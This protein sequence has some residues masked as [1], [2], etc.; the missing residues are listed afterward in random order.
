MKEP[1]FDDPRVKEQLQI[2]DDWSKDV[3]LFCDEALNI[4]PAQPLGALCGTPIKY[5][6]PF[7]A[8]QTAILFD[9]RGHLV[10]PDLAFYTRDMFEPWKEA[11]ER[12]LTWQQ[13]VILEAYNR[14]LSTFDADSFD[15]VKRWVST[16]AG[17]GIGKTSCMSIIALHFLVCFPGAQIGATAASEN[18]LKDIFLKEFY[19]WRDKLPDGIKKD[20]TQLDDMV[21]VG[22]GKDW[23]MRARVSRPD[24]PE[25]LAGL[26]G[27]YVL[28]LPD[29]A[30][31]IDNMTFQIMKGALTGKNYIV[32]YFSNG[33]RTEG[34]FWESQKKGS[35]FTRLQFSSLDSPIVR[36]GYAD[37]ISADYGGTGSDEYKI[38]VL[39]QFAS[40]DEMDDKGWIPLF[41]NLRFLFEPEQGQIIARPLIACDPAGAG[42]DRSIVHV[43]DNVYLKEVLS[44]RTSSPQDLARKIETIRDAY[45]SVSN[46]IAID[47][48]GIGAQVVANISTK[49][50]ESVNALLTDKPRIGTEDRFATFRDELA[51]KFRQWVAGGGIIITNNT[52][53]WLRELNGVKYKRDKQGRIHLQSKVDYRKAMGFSPDR[54]DAAI[55]TFFKDEP[56]QPVIVRRE[57]LELIQ[58][59]RLIRENQGLPLNAPGTPAITQSTGGNSGDSY[60]SM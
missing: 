45:R 14:A 35:R 49:M 37:M 7:G 44:E 29:E 16:V 42:R 1:S 9:S 55:Y 18:Q 31:G 52:Q 2:L 53:A 22:D 4:K 17:H 24:K 48:F 10:Y 47:A 8:T 19:V 40:V 5:R 13:T 26:H 43:R 38:R 58:H 59:A 28:L 27:D 36:L 20:I 32:M 30:S 12:S 15:M 39:G 33:T 46:D 50:G 21:K 41:A 3:F 23:F 51:W 60:S 11:K 34:E 6:D 57:D 56:S 54:F 25:A